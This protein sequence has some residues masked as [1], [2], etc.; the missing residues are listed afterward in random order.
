MPYA[1]DNCSACLLE[2]FTAG[3]AVRVGQL[4]NMPARSVQYKRCRM[5]RTTAPHTCWDKCAVAAWNPHLCNGCT[6]AEGVV[7]GCDW[8]G[9]S[10]GER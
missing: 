2:Q 3:D 6:A 7:A 8:L 10:L 1:V 4:F 5:R 9:R